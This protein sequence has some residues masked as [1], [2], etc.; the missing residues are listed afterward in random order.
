VIADLLLLQEHCLKRSS[1]DDRFSALLYLS[2]ESHSLVLIAQEKRS[3]S[4]SS[5]IL[6]SLKTAFA[7]LTVLSKT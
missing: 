4:D 1:C 2:K 6:G 7:R 5:P 3:L